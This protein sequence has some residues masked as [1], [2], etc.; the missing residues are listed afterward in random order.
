MFIV[1]VYKYQY[2]AYKLKTSTFGFM[3]IYIRK[4]DQRIVKETRA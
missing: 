3:N 2:K 4:S 1:L